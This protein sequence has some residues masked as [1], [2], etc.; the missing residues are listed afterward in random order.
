MNFKFK[1]GVTVI[2]LLIV[3]AIIGIFITTGIFTGKLQ[4][5]KGKDGKR[6]ADLKKMQ[7]VF[8]DYHNDA[9]RYPRPNEIS[10]GGVICRRNF[11]P[12]LPELPC[13]P[14]NSSEHNYYY[15]TTDPLS[16]YKIYTKLENK[17]D[18]VIAEVG[19]RWGCGPGNNYNYWIGSPNV[20]W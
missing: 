17:S 2:E 7:T 14:V 8:E 3:L 4:F 11:S 1:A 5:G 13:D 9:Q 12:Y 18:P 10:S 20:N 6:K 16:W 15:Q 19:C